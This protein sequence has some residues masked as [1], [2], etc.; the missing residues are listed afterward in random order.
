MSV[1]GCA[2]NLTPQ[3]N[4]IL[5]RAQ[6]RGQLAK[7]RKGISV[8]LVQPY[9]FEENVSQI[10]QSVSELFDLLNAN[11]S[12]T[13]CARVK[14]RLL[15]LEN[16]INLSIYSDKEKLEVIDD[17]NTQ[18]LTLQGMLIEHSETQLK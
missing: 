6:L 1:G 2:S 12:A 15:H 11:V 18:L 16:R 3:D 4:Q 13:V 14:S 17:L 7:E 8:T 9:E 10:E 5:R